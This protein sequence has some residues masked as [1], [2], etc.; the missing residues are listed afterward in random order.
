MDTAVTILDS[1]KQHNFKPRADYE[2]L[3]VSLNGRTAFLAL[4]YRGDTVSSLGLERHE[5]WYSAQNEMLHTVNGRV[6]RAI[7]FTVEWRAQASSPPSWSA[8]RRSEVEVAWS[9]SLDVMPG[10]RFGQEG[11]LRTRP[12]PAPV[13]A[14]QG[15]PEGVSWFEDIVVS[16]TEDN[17]PWEFRQRFAVLNDQVVYSE[18][19]LSPKACLRLRPLSRMGNP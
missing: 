9:R 5:F 10:Y 14:P 15:I 6:Q 4:G 18:Q 13:D 2:Y 8:V 16:T 17:Q 1:R 3:V 12:T 7:G 19:C 11:H